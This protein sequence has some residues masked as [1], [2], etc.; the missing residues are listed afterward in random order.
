VGN[1]DAKRVAQ[2]DF[3]RNFGVSEDNVIYEDLY[4]GQMVIVMENY[5]KR[6]FYA[7]TGELLKLVNLEGY[8]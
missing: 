1:E 5:S 8:N 3:E 4:E 2:E 6:A 7:L